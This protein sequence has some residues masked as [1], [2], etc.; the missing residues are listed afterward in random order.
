MKKKEKSLCIIIHLTKKLNLLKK[1][2]SFTD[3]IIRKIT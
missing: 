3:K 1:V 2:F